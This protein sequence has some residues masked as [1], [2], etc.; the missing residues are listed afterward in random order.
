MTE[1]NALKNFLQ[2]SIYC[3]A[4]IETVPFGKLFVHPVVTTLSVIIR[5]VF[6]TLFCLYFVCYTYI[7]RLNGTSYPKSVWM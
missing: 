7:L 1:A 3:S 2:A 6:A 4:D 5:H